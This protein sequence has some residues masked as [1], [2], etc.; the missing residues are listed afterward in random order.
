MKLYS[1]LLMQN[2]SGSIRVMVD[3][4]GNGPSTKD[5]EHFRRSLKAAPDYI[6]NKGNACI[7]SQSAFLSNLNNK[8]FFIKDLM[9][10]LQMDGV[11]VYQAANDADT[12]TVKTFLELA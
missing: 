9:E 12:V 2:I 7:S 3:I 8:K 1:K 5:H 4:Y 10:I 11:I 6:V